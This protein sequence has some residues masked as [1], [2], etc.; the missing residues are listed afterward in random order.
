MFLTKRP[1]EFNFLKQAL[2]QPLAELR[3][4]PWSG[5][6]K[7]NK[8]HVLD[9]DNSEL[10]YLVGLV[11]TDFI[12]KCIKPIPRR[13]KERDLWSPIVPIVK[14]LS[15]VEHSASVVNKI[16]LPEETGSTWDAEEMVPEVVYRHPLIYLTEDLISEN[17]LDCPRNAN[18]DWSIAL[19]VLLTEPFVE[20]HERYSGLLGQQKIVNCLNALFLI[21][22]SISSSIR[23]SKQESDTSFQIFYPKTITVQQ[24]VYRIAG[25]LVSSKAAGQHFWCLCSIDGQVMKVDNM[26]P[27]ARYL[28]QNLHGKIRTTVFVVCHLLD[29]DEQWNI[30]LDKWYNRKDRHAF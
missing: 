30:T 28:Q 5:Y 29:E 16:T 10:V 9:D 12:A 15:S 3:H 2:N 22:P 17:E 18:A 20:A 26:M 19:T 25:R 11:L 21:D 27:E 7:T 6:G 13:M 8:L 1:R 14:Y 23:R 4:F 24:R